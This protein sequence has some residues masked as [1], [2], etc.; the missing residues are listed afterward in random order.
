[1][2]K[3][4]VNGLSL[5][6]VSLVVPCYNTSSFIEESINSLLE[7]TY[8]NIEIILID[9]GSLDATGEICDKLALKDNRITV[10]HQTNQ[11]VSAAR[12][13][14]L[15]DAK[16]EY[17][18]F[19]DSDDV[20]R[21]NAVEILYKMIEM[22]HSEV[23]MAQRFNIYEDGIIKDGNVGN[24]DYQ[25]Y[26]SKELVNHALYGQNGA[27]STVIG[28][29]YSRELLSDLRF[30]TNIH[31]AED[32]LFNI[33]AILKAK[34]T[35]VVYYPIYGYRIRTGS[36]MRTGFKQDRMGGLEALDKVAHLT[37]M[38]QSGGR[39]TKTRRFIECINILRLIN[40]DSQYVKEVSVCVDI[41]K[42]SRYHV[43]FDVHAPLRFRLY[44]FFS[45]VHPELP[46]SFRRWIDIPRNKS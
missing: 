25:K 17:V 26:G 40:N 46:A 35:C 21:K 5:P 2:S 37:G 9:D 30:D 42:S 10:V 14:G 19:V 44:A 23:V 12:N 15:D 33:T 8:T 29:L 13:T 22:T 38:S 36:A 27:T 32:I 20:L 24:L 34:L 18:V 41:I 31:Y 6:L 4:S 1:M 3:S 28:N 43:L 45:Y 11:G 39:A 7:Q 16:G